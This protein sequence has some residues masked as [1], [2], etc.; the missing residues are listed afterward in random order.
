M[1]TFSIDPA[2][3]TSRPQYVKEMRE[4]RHKNM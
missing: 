4:V 1:L 3:K 2:V